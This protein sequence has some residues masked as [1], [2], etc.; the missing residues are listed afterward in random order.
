MYLREN[1]WRVAGEIKG[2]QGG[3]WGPRREIRR[4][5]DDEYHFGTTKMDLA[6]RIGNCFDQPGRRVPKDR[7]GSHSATSGEC[8]LT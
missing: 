1:R 3:R 4:R 5:I 8:L 7:H 2:L 6:F